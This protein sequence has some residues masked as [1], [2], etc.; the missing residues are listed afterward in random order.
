MSLMN[1]KKTALF[2]KSGAVVPTAPANFLEVSEELLLT[3]DIPIEEFKRINGLLGSNASY[4]DTCHTTISQTVET[5]MRHQNSAADALN[6]VPEYG[7]LLKIG[8]F[9]ED[10]TAESMV[11]ASVSGIVL[12]DTITGDTSSASGVVVAINSV[13]DTLVLSPVTSGPFTVGGE[14]LNTATYT[15]TSAGY[16]PRYINTQTPVLGSAVA[17]ID[18]YKHEMTGSIAAD[19]T[20]NFPIG[21]AAMISAALS[22]FLDNS[23]IAGSEATPAVTLNPEAVLLVGCADILTAGGTALKPD[24][25]SIAMG[26]DIQEFY[27]MGELKEF[28]LKDYI[29]KI[30]AD[31]YPENANYNDAVT[32]LGAETTEAISV[33]LGTTAGDNVNGKTVQIDCALGKVNT[34]SDSVDKS[35]LKRSVTWLL[36]GTEQLS[37]KHGFYA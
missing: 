19:L 15:S 7:E 13:A 5:K 33:T 25:I 14:D 8:G 11:L 4:A 20:L 24:N 35:T 12:G 23:G 10:L 32:K 37:I 1:T 27:G 3:P 6:D 9:E 31:S 18:G 30:T 17:Y 29:V 26:A 34:F 21:K 2:L 22:A 36:G 16:S 28:N